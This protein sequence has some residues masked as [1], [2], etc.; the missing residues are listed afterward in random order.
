LK[1][2]MQTL[3]D[4]IQCQCRHS[5]V[6]IVYRL[7]RVSVALGLRSSHAKTAFTLGIAKQF[8]RGI[9]S[10]GAIALELRLGMQCY[11][12]IKTCMREVMIWF[13]IEPDES[14]EALVQHAKEVFMISGIGTEKKR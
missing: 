9:E 10:Q 2:C 14:D 6:E 13:N 3:D 12:M 5:N 1:I 4:L 7:R 11:A 8:V